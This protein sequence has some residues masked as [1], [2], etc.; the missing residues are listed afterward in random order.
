[1]AARI[2]RLGSCIGRRSACSEVRVQPPPHAATRVAAQRPT[3]PCDLNGELGRVR[4]GAADPIAAV[5]S[6]LRP[7]A[8][9]VHKP[10]EAERPT[11]CCARPSTPRFTHEDALCRLHHTRCGG[12]VD[13]ASPAAPSTLICA[14]GGVQGSAGELNPAVACGATATRRTARRR[15]GGGEAATARGRGGADAAARRRLG[16]SEAARS[17]NLSTRHTARRRCD[18]DR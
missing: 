13:G 15:R 9:A 18:G 12:G 5:P 1:M 17:V 2:G 6:I 10:S 8:R 3:D 16:C 4:A 11:T 14:G 7:L